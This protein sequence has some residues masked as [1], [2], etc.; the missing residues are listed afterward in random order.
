MAK[1]AKLEGRIRYVKDYFGRGEHY[2]FENKWSDETEWGL[3]V[4]TPIIDDM[5]HY[6]ALTKIRQWQKLGIEF[7]F[8]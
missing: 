3:E 8:V 6:T 1:K 7:Y 5:V 4:A 2:V